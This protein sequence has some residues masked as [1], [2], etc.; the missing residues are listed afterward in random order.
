MKYLGLDLRLLLGSVSTGGNHE[1]PFYIAGHDTKG[2]CSMA[3]GVP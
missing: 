1:V 2:G 3:V